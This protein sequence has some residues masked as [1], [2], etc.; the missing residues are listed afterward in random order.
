MKIFATGGY[1]TFLDCPANIIKNHRF[2]SLT[3]GSEH[4]LK[5]V[6]YVTWDNKWARKLSWCKRWYFRKNEYF[7]RFSYE[8]LASGA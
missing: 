8:S 3:P 5:A 6:R 4:L 2:E 7:S 1:F